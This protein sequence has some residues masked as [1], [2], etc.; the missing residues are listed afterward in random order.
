MLARAEKLVLAACCSSVKSEQF[1]FS[2]NSA[3]E[4]LEENG[5]NLLDEEIL[6]AFSSLAEKDFCRF[7]QH[8]DSILL[9]NTLFNHWVNKYQPLK[10]VG[11]RDEYDFG[12]A[13]R[14]LATELGHSFKIREQAEIIRSLLGETL[15]PEWLSICGV[16]ETGKLEILSSDGNYLW[17]GESVENLSEQQRD[18]LKALL[19]PV[20]IDQLDS[21]QSQALESLGFK[22]GN[23]LVPVISRS[24]LIAI[25]TLGGKDSGQGRYS[26]K[27]FILFQTVAEQCA[28]SFE[29]ARMYEEETEKER[30][31]QELDMAR[32]MQFAILPKNE[33]EIEGID[34]AAFI[35]PATEVGGDYYDF[36]VLD[37]RKLAFLVGDVSGHGI[38]AGTLVSMSKSCIFNQLKADYS[39][40]QVMGSMNEMVKGALA[41]RLLMTFCY[42]IF[43]LE[44]MSLEYSIAGHPFPYRS[45]VGNDKIE[46]LEMSAY[47]LGVSAKAQYSSATTDL[48]PGDLLIFYSDGITEGVNRSAEQ[49]GFERFEKLIL[50]FRELPTREIV[51]KITG[52]FYDFSEGHPQE[53]DITLVAIKIL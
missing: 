19:E 1:L 18:S 42:S 52:T 6:K 11:S 39:V 2:V 38:S 49:W 17:P 3:Y 23:L 12:A 5:L 22:K 43:D 31:R 40:P 37:S 24:G 45:R 28:V 35:S 44:K 4:I 48:K 9:D 36:K 51:E 8:S 47:P 26:R 21:S 13:V 25:I 16:A 10:I 32:R 14:F 53:D 30:M 46:E 29:N 15:K 20:R 50:E 7:E 41:E 27:D 33:P 34:F